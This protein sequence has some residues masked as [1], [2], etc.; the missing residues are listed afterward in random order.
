MIEID[1]WSSTSENGDPSVQPRPLRETLP[2]ILTIL[3]P[4]WPIL[5]LTALLGLML[6][7]LWLVGPV[8]TGLLID[9]AILGGD[10]Q[11]LIVL[12]LALMGVALA[13]IV[14][15]LLQDYLLLLS[16]EMAVRSVRS[17]LFEALQNQS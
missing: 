10:T 14:L 5:T 1:F 15:G 3:A 13:T 7:I 16:S 11:L 12:C 6:S 9:R 2:R 17:T 4:H 8:L